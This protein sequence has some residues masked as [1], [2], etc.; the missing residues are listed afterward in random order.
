MFQWNWNRKS[1][2]GLLSGIVVPGTGVGGGAV[3]MI[4][5]NSMLSVFDP[6]GVANTRALSIL[7]G[8]P[9]SVP[10]IQ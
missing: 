2:L 5:A 4:A 9:P 6:R 10:P 7:R 1:G 3:T 8:F